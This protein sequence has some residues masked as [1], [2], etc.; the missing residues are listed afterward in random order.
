MNPKELKMQGLL[1]AYLRINSSGNNFDTIDHLDEDTLTA[2]VEGKLTEQ[3]AKPT[4]SHLVGCSFCRKI[5]AELI[6]LDLAFAEDTQPVLV[7]QNEQTK[8]SEVLNRILSRIF[9][10]NDGAV[11]AHHESDEDEAEEEEGKTEEE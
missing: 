8:V 2:F 3:E 5:T 10:T 9:G 1:D 11:F 4:T 7:G 6:K